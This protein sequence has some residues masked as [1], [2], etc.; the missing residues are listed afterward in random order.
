MLMVINIQESGNKIE[1]MDMVYMSIRI[2]ERDMKDSGEM[3]LKKV[4]VNFYSVMETNMKESLEK[5][6]RVDMER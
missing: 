6:R 1:N 2:Q 5:V 3:E 4:K